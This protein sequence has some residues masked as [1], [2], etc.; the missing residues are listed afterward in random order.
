M[1]VVFGFPIYFSLAFHCVWMNWLGRVIYT[2]AEFLFYIL[3]C[4]T[5]RWADKKSASHTLSAEVRKRGQ[6]LHFFLFSLRKDSEDRRAILQNFAAVLFFKSN[7]SCF[8]STKLQLNLVLE[9]Y[10]RKGKSDLSQLSQG[11]PAPAYPVAGP[12]DKGSPVRNLQL[13]TNLTPLQTWRF[14]CFNV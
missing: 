12:T 9:N 7:S 13:G 14:R 1:R 6:G 5:L 4:I 2:L 3:V 11:L 10:S 8:V